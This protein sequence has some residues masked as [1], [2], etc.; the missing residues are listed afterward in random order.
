MYVQG[1]DISKIVNSNN[2]FSIFDGEFAD[3][4]F[5]IKHTEPGLL[6]MC[7]RSRIPHTNEC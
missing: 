3:E 2:G 5:D 4:S 6:G 1:G 7:K